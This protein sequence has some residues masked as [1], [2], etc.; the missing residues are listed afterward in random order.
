MRAKSTATQSFL[1]L[2]GAG[3]DDKYN[4]PV[5]EGRSY[6]APIRPEHDH[7]AS[8]LSY[9]TCEKIILFHSVRE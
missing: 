4:Q 1:A 7:V 8:P 5:T 9:D 3:F 2:R 6:V